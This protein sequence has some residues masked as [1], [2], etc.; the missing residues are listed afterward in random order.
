MQAPGPQGSSVPGQVGVHSE[1]TFMEETN[2][3]VKNTM[4]A[5]LHENDEGFNNDGFDVRR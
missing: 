3:F 5:R 1:G 2:K 4:A